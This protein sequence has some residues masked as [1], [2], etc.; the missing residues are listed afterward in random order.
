MN[1]VN[2]EYLREQNYKH[3]TGAIF[4][5][6]T[7]ITIPAA[8]IE[9]AVMYAAFAGISATLILEYAMCII[10]IKICD[11]VLFGK[12]PCRAII[13]GLAGATILRNILFVSS[14]AASAAGIIRG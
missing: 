10:S 1:K 7:V 11:I 9:S 14:I 3:Q 12:E 8:Y 2:I 5:A 6:W 13:R 4:I